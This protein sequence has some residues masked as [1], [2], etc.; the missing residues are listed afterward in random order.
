M[1]WNVQVSIANSDTSIEIH[2]NVTGRELKIP[3]LIGM[4]NE[5]EHNTS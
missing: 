3:K 1:E 5:R 2:L 4:R